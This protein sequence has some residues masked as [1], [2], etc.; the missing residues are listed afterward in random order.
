METMISK[1]VVVLALLS[2][3]SCSSE[4]AQ[5][6]AADVS[7]VTTNNAPTVSD[8]IVSIDED[9]ILIHSL[10]AN[11][12]EGDA[13]TY[14]ITQQPSN[15]VASVVGNQVTYQ[16]NANF[17][18]SDNFE[19]IAD[20]GALQSSVGVVDITVNPVNDAPSVA[21]VSYQLNED[22]S[23][24]INLLATD[25]DG[26]NVFFSVGSVSNGE[27]AGTGSV[28]TYFP[29]NNWNGTDS[30]TYIANDG[31][32]NNGVSN[33]GVISL[34]VIAVNDA[35]FA[36]SSSVVVAEGGSLGITL[37][38]SDADGDVL[39]YSI[40]SAPVN[41]ALTLVG[42]TATYTPNPL[43]N[44]ADS[45]SFV[46]NDGSLSSASASIN[47]TVTGVN[48]QPVAN[49][50]SVVLDEDNTASVTL[51][52]S[53]LD[54]DVLLYALSTAPS[55]GSV[56]ITG[57]V[58]YYTP[59]EN[60]NGVD[61][62]SFVSNDGTV[63]SVAAVV[64]VTVN[65]VNDAPVAN[66]G[67][68]IVQ[69]DGA[70]AI[71]LNASDA[72]ADTLTYSIVNNPTRGVLS[73]TAPNLT[74]TPNL[75]E[76]GT[77]V[78]TYMVTDGL[79]NSATVA[80]DITIVAVNDAPQAAN[81]SLT[82]NEDTMAAI[83]LS[84]T[85]ADLD[86][87][88][89]L[90]NTAPLNGSLNIVGD[91]ASYTPN[92][93]FNGTDS[94]KFV[95]NDGTGD[96]L[97][98]TV[99]ITVASI[100]DAPVANAASADVFEDG[101]VAIT[102]NALD[103]D[104]DTL[105]Y[106]IVNNPARGN[107]TGTAPNLTYTP[108]LN[109]NGADIFTYMV[110]D[111]ALDSSTVAVEITISAVNDLPVASSNAVT[112]NED[113]GTTVT[114]LA[115]DVDLDNLTYRVGTAPTNGS[116]NIVGDQATYTPNADFN[117]AD[118]FS[119]VANDGSVDSNAATVNVSVT[120]VNDAPVADTGSYTVDEDG[121]V[122]ITLTGSDVDG[123][124]LFYSLQTNPT[125]GSLSGVSP[126]YTYTPDADFNGVDSFAFVVSDGTLNSALTTVNIVINPVN[127]APFANI[128]A[129]GEVNGGEYLSLDG[130]S[131]ID[132]D[133]DS[134]S[135]AWT[136]TGGV[137]VELEDLTTNSLSFM[138]PET[139]GELSFQLT[140]SDS[141]LS[142]STDI[143]VNNLGYSGAAASSLTKN[144][145]QRSVFTGESVTKTVISGAYAYVTVNNVGLNIYDISNNAADPVLVGQ[146]A[147][148][149]GLNTVAL[150]TV[151]GVTYA[152]IGTTPGALP[153]NGWVIAD[154]TDPANPVALAER[155]IGGSLSIKSI[156]VDAASN[157]AYLGTS[158]GFVYAYDITTPANPGSQKAVSAVNALTGS[159]MVSGGYV[160]VTDIYGSFIILDKTT[161]A[162]VGRYNSNVTGG[163]RGFDISGNYAFVAS[164]PSVDP[165]SVR[166]VD[167][168]DPAVPVKVAE[169]TELESPDRVTVSSNIVYVTDYRVG[170]LAL[171]I[172]TPTTPV[173]VGSYQD[174]ATT[175]SV[176]VS[177]SDLYLG[178]VRGQT[179]F[180][181]TTL[182]EQSILSAYANGLPMTDVSLNGDQLYLST[183]ANNHG[184]DILDMTDIYNPAWLG[185]ST[186]STVQMVRNRGHYS[187]MA[188]GN[189]FS[190]YDLSNP[191]ANFSIG[192]F[193]VGGTE[194][195]S[196]KLDGNR[197][198]A[199]AD[200]QLKIYDITDTS[201]PVLTGTVSGYANA[202][203]MATMANTVFVAEGTA[204]RVLDVTDP[205]SVTEI[206]Q[207]SHPG[208][209]FYSGLEIYNNH[210]YASVLS[211][212]LLNSG[213]YIYDVSTPAT[214][215]ALGMIDEADYGF[216][217]ISRKDNTLV[218]KGNKWGGVK[219]LV[220]RTMDLSN[221]AAP[222]LSGVYDIPGEL[223]GVALTKDLLFAATGTEGLKIVERSPVLSGTQTSVM[224]GSAPLSYSVSWMDKQVP[225]DMS[226]LCYVSGGSCI[227]N[228]VDQ[229]SN[230]ASVE[231]TLP[232]AAD[233]Y[234]IVIVVGNQ[235]GFM[236]T[237]DR[238]Q[239]ISMA[240]L[241][242][243]ITG[244][245][246]NAGVSEISYTLTN[247]G[248]LGINQSV[249][250]YLVYVT[251]WDN[252]ASPPVMGDFRTSS[253]S[254]LPLAA[255][256][257]VSIWTGVPQSAVG[258]TAY[259]I[260]DTQGYVPESDDSN[261][262]SAGFAW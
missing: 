22:S 139:A 35:P 54:G 152:Y 15:G 31:H 73:G 34:N 94:F 261:N 213:V 105:T 125:Q 225:E 218:L 156:H 226:V 145:F 217:A 48:N 107:L 168:T 63:N 173:L 178:N 95:A 79:L 25:V 150:H 155:N 184:L 127:D 195:R 215:S 129:V 262:I 137:A 43:Y 78:F 39:S 209:D 24:T 237:K 41:G 223:N 21:D 244:V 175:T 68:A 181:L 205:A 248:T 97:A 4:S 120:A 32:A 80:V 160:Y 75:N 49:A 211:S 128:S 206:T 134:L 162:Q 208:A 37:T 177:G 26:E 44:G 202:T 109:A 199:L 1:I 255:G 243:E 117:G 74:Y 207:I 98:A 5:P 258:G 140:V 189:S 171:D 84:A 245:V 55:N 93:D 198:Y 148:A 108:N 141:V 230:T 196:L 103:V 159:M 14:S 130:S 251:C 11:D 183:S 23:I 118:S 253:G 135:Y 153:Y 46:V 38:A 241:V 62:F 143:V 101:A 53:D 192:Y 239:V 236:T 193:Y 161:L 247:Q 112:T 119:F 87:L 214:P 242:V 96:S 259:C 20:D 200:N 204:V 221:P 106:S 91:Q 186:A 188:R 71:T 102:L 60:F 64:S 172:T 70:I 164:L 58:A 144:P 146:L 67:T 238:V 66:A 16:P 147:L 111:G 154:V 2:V 28:Y 240:D 9:L 115:T 19:Y 234:E 56:A 191:A 249:S 121:S 142:T 254:Y 3:L 69:E 250:E 59:N 149:Q 110:T 222:V 10:V 29:N 8:A 227:V 45:F 252:L 77:D 42:N 167:I 163:A 40:T 47:I 83:T 229:F 158:M 220:T 7:P 136:Q 85:D 257:S 260:A 132:V 219:S 151:G 100:N 90:V 203:A 122:A 194:I 51:T 235:R 201:T 174:N 113:T 157:T 13:L 18:G 233:D 246:V 12:P 72:D 185:Y 133:G 114:L 89:Y 179:I 224:S 169:F 210:L 126:N 256:G 50:G 33:T 124:A 81:N 116:L 212:S 82:T 123:Q 88:T 57:N 180:D 170:V 52:G 92:A 166:V 30:F 6:P 76:N 190:V 138:A 228:S 187:Y 216:G 86:A 182:S 104:G 197:L 17:N 131:S 232:A 36:N 165:A 65:A 27:L 99:T 61:S 176:T 231:W